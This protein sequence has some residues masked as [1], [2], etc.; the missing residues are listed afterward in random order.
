MET[1]KHIAL[2]NKRIDEIIKR[3]QKEI[4]DNAECAIEGKDRW[5]AV[6]SRILGSTNAAVRQLK[7]ELKRNWQVKHTPSTT[8]EDVIE[9]RPTVKVQ[10]RR[11]RNDR[12]K[13]PKTY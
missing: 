10:D 5:L 2:L 11:Y 3:A 8:Y 7:T 9:I 1:D 12:S 4:L 13:N 6:R